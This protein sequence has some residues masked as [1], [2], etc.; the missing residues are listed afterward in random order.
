MIFQVPKGME[1]Y[2]IIH[3]I[4]SLE[5]ILFNPRIL[6]HLQNKIYF[7]TVSRVDYLNKSFN[8]ACL[9]I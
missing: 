7:E 3:N 5:V 4:L 8:S 2:K 6:C 9:N 1:G